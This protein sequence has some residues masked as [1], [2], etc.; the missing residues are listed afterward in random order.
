MSFNIGIYVFD[1][2]EVLDFAGPYE[3][4]TTAAGLHRRDSDTD[5]ALFNVFT[6]GRTPVPIHARAG[7]KVDPDHGIHTHPKLDGSILKAAA[8]CAIAAKAVTH[9]A[10][11]QRSVILFD[12]APRPATSL[13]GSST[14]RP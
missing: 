1:E 7:L 2:V 5:A 6:V 14:D 12:L 10:A 13:E 11:A 3:V 8:Q 4:F 9:K